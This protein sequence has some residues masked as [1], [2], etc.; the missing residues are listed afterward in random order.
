MTTIVNDLYFNITEKTLIWK[1][2]DVL[3][4]EWSDITT[5]NIG[6]GTHLVYTAIQ[7]ESDDTKIPIARFPQQITNLIY[8]K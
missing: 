8:Q 5:L 1:R 4:R 3:I 7:K 6:D 2:N